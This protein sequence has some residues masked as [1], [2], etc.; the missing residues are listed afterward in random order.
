MAVAELTLNLPWAPRNPEPLD[1]ITIRRGRHNVVS[2]DDGITL[3]VRLVDPSGHDTIDDLLGDV[4]AEGGAGRVV[5]VAGTIPV[6]WRGRLR[7]EE[8]SFIDVSGTASIS[9]PR[10]HASTRR[11][12]KQPVRRTALVPLQKARPIV[13][14]EVLIT[15]T[16]GSAPTLGEITEST[17]TG[18]SV[19]SRALSQLADQGLILKERE[20]RQIRVRVTEPW[21]LAEHLAERTA[22][23]KGELLWGALWG[24]NAWEL[25]SRLSASARASGITLA[26]TGRTGAAFH[27][28]VGTTSPGD[29][30]C[31]VDTGGE[32][33]SDIAAVLGLEPV[34]IDD[35]NVALATDRWRVGTHRR[36]T[37]TFEDW[38]A[39]VAHPLRLW[40]D[41]RAERRGVEFATQLWRFVSDAW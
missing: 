11:F 38:Q 30:R 13:A 10:L 1:G 6:H 21:A 36:S 29:V 22:W 7:G 37:V 28:V 4:A 24:R 34:P 19:V 15:A 25:A 41:L 18:P 40:C 26:V 16:G 9:W 14:Q 23:G 5:L 3:E 27:G 17:D 12:A 8:V 39:T 20:G 31:W 32:Q 33:L 2:Y 35:A